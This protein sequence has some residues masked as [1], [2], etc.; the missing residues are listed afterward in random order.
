MLK[1]KEMMEKLQSG[2][3][4]LNLKQIGL[5]LSTICSMKMFIRNKSQSTEEVASNNSKRKLQSNY[6]SQ[7]RILFSSVEAHMVLNSSRTN[8]VANR[9]TFI[10]T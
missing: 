5:L 7:H 6:T 9:P 1:K 4:N 2:N 3:K 8:L 10:I